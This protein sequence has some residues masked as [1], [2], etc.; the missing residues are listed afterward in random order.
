MDPDLFDYMCVKQ[1]AR[2]KGVS[3]RTVHRWI[4]AGNLTAERAGALGHWRIAVPR[5]S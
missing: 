3:S 1:Y 5:E 2:W 4:R